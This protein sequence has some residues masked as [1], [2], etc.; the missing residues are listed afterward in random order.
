M[1]PS[2]FVLKTLKIDCK[3]AKKEAKAKR[4]KMNKA[5]WPPTSI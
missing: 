4:K 3:K 5:D 1:P 2:M